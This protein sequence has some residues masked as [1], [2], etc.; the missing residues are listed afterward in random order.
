[1]RPAAVNPRRF[2]EVQ[3]KALIK[4]LRED[5]SLSYKELARRLEAQGVVMDDQ[6]L[7]NRINRGGFSFAFALQLLAAMDVH[8]LKV[9][10]PP[11]PQ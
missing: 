2:Y 4:Q 11:K 3:A 5:K 1:V 8:T 9:P 10:R 7:I 6:V